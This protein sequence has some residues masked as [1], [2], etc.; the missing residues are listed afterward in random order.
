M[1]IGER[2]KKLREEKGLTQEQFSNKIKVT[3]SYISHLE[4]G[5]AEPSP[6]VML[7]IHNIFGVRDE[8]LKTGEGEMYD[9][10]EKRLEDFAK[11]LGEDIYLKHMTAKA[12]HRRYQE[13]AESLPESPP[14]GVAEGQQGYDTG[15]MTEIIETVEELFEE[16]NLSLPPKKKAQLIELLYQELSEDPGDA[17]KL[18]GK[19]LKFTRLAS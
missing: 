19:I 14:G 3:R 8:W 16:E 7:T 6:I 11:E 1:N 18:K 13:I 2:V 4:S 12:G 5:K 10:R 9:D 17:D 15:L